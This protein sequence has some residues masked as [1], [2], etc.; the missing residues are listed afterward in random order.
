MVGTMVIVVMG[1][2]GSGGESM[3]RLLAESLGWEFADMESLDC[4]AQMRSGLPDTG[5]MP[6][7]EVLSAA[8]DSSTCEWRDL[9][10]SC[11]ALKEK[12]QWQLRRNHP[13]VKFVSLRAPDSVDQSLVPAQASAAHEK[14]DSILAV[15]TSQGAERI[16][17]AVL[18]SLILK[19]TGKSPHAA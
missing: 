14:N 17:G 8:V 11:P 4:A 10:I 12:D 7:I 9:I 19:R 6:Q 16:I 18:S 1:E 2:V 3:G 13:L 5:R 15:D